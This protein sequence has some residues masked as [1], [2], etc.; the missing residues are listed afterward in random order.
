VG[1]L[2]ATQYYNECQHFLHLEMGRGG[3]AKVKKCF[4][5]CCTLKLDNIVIPNEEWY[6][7]WCDPVSNVPCYHQTF[8]DNMC[9]EE[10]KCMHEQL[11]YY[12]GTTN[13]TASWN[14]YAFGAE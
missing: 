6:S 9:M 11:Q 13:A 8:A 4:C 14:L 7:K 10:Y 5:H 3:T 12:S 2:Q 1:R